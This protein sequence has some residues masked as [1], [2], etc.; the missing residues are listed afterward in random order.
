[1]RPSAVSSRRTCGAA[2]V[3][4]DEVAV[5]GRPAEGSFTSDTGFISAYSAMATGISD[6]VRVV[7]PQDNPPPNAESNTRC[8]AF[9][10]P[11]VTASLNS[12]GMDAV[13]QFPIRSIFA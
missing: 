5:M 11:E 1:M 9:N 8:P 12:R 6:H 3:G 2:N 10:L 13:R 4:R 7:A